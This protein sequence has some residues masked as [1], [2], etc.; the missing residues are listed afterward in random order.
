MVNR[1]LTQPLALAMVHASFRIF[2]Y[3]M[4]NVALGCEISTFQMF[5]TP[6]QIANDK[7]MTRGGLSIQ[8]VV[9]AYVLDCPHSGYL[10][11]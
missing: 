4:M 9:E 10:I 6:R 5:C 7:Y 8:W 3:N 2:N 1:K 11:T